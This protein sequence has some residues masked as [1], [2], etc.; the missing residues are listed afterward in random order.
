MV[1]AA[2]VTR[3]FP[4][5][6]LPLLVLV[7]AI[8]LVSCGTPVPSSQGPSAAAG[9]PV[10]SQPKSTE[11]ALPTGS[12]LPTPA[13]SGFAF[14]DEAVIGYYQSQG[15]ACGQVQPSS[16]AAG[17]FYRGCQKVDASGR[18]LAIGLVTDPSGALADAYASVQ[19]TAT[20]TILNP[21]DALDHLA[22]FLGAM[23]GT[24]RGNSLLTWLA[25]H[26]GD[27][28][29]ETTIDILRVATYTQSKTD[30]SRL[31]VELANHA[32]LKA[33]LPSAS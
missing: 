24:V 33:P 23:L 28:Y 10:S 4:R 2:F 14:S 19:G 22:G 6:H 11:S 15:F 12:A 16:S 17:Y 18:T 3:A 31:Y 9:S 27:E 5:L 25:G 21:T 13:P 26:L 1:P 29:A 32:Y 20:E 8:L 30:H 7:L